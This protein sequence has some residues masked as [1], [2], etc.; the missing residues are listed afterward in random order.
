MKITQI[1]T[2]DLKPYKLNAKKHPQTQVEGIAESIRRFGFTQP[3][4]IDG[5]NEIIIGHGRLEAAKLAGLK[6]VPCI[7]LSDLSKDEV[8]AL[9]LI[10]NRISETGWD[11]EILALEFNDLDFDFSKFNVEFDLE[12]TEEEKDCRSTDIPEKEEAKKKLSE[13]FLIPPFSV[14]NAREGWWQ[15]RKR[16]WFG[17]GIKSELGRGDN[18][19]ELSD[20]CEIK[21]GGKK[22]KLGKCLETGIGENYGR[23]EMNATSIFDPVLCEIAYRWFCPPSGLILDPFAGGSVRGIVAAKLGRKYTGIDLRSEQIKANEKQW[24]KI[25]DSDLLNPNWYCGDS[26]DIVSILP[27]TL[28]DFI[29]TCPP[30]ADLEV[31]SY[32]PK[33]LST[34]DYEEFKSVYSEIIK[35]T[36]SKLKENRFA[37]II[38][39]EVRDKK[40]NYYNFVG[41]TIQAFL[42]AGLKYYNEAILVTS[43]GSLPIRAG[44][45]FSL[46]RKIGKTHQNILVFVKGDGKK[47]AQECGEVDLS[48]MEEFNAEDNL[49]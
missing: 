45:I 47:A 42:D 10:D 5:S 32:D 18:L 26:R 19:L 44:R 16:A 27:N 29:F 30:Y 7:K 36:C 25:S 14:L 48:G 1:K 9:R 38:V 21:L 34:L 37:C 49:E 15:D 23:E 2:D 43:V 12:K 6:D 17:I 24:E 41:D 13:R 31:Y 3:I 40:G 22:N 39:G 46:G 20:S 35:K 4:V 33:D 28:H 11:S 8:K